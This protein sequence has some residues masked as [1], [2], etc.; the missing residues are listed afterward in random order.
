VSANDDDASSFLLQ[1]EYSTL[2][3]EEHSGDVLGRLALARGV[4]HPFPPVT[5]IP[6]PSRLHLKKTHLN[7]TPLVKLWAGC[8]GGRSWAVDLLHTSACVDHN[9]YFVIIFHPKYK[10][11]SCGTAFSH[12][13]IYCPSDMS[14]VVCDTSLVGGHQRCGETYCLHLQGPESTLTM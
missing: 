2:W 8:M 12:F 9:P 7:R 5:D 4:P 1:M 13:A 11:P 10:F 14:L 3:V 6:A